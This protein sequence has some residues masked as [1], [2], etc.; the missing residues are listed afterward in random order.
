M[1]DLDRRNAVHVFDSHNLEI[2]LGELDAFHDLVAY[3]DAKLD[4]IK[5]FS[6]SYCGEE[7]LLAHYFLNYDGKTKRHVI[8]P[9]DG[10][11]GFDSVLIGEGEWKDFIKLEQYNNKK[12]EDATSYFWDH[13]IQKTCENALNGTLQGNADLLKGPSAL[14]I[15]AKEPRFMWEGRRKARSTEDDF[16]HVMSAAII[17]R[18]QN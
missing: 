8:G 4:A 3:F 9:R 18:L 7:D 1:L 10:D 11:G 15:M 17:R 5:R 13:L 6:L 12:K 14:H 2:L 16:A